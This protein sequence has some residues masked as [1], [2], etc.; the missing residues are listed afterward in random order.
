METGT[1]VLDNITNNNFVV[2]G[3]F[4]DGQYLL[5]EELNNHESEDLV[6]DLYLEKNVVFEDLQVILRY[7]H[8][9]TEL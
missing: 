1:L 9:I 8:Q 2:V 6:E 4:I 5:I 7:P 3:K